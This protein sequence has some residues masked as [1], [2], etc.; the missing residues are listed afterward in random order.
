MADERGQIQP[1]PANLT[2]RDPDT[3]NPPRLSSGQRREAVSP[4]ASAVN[5]ASVRR[6]L[7]WVNV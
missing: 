3:Q 2:Q 1:L 5:S 7:E 4:W 6:A